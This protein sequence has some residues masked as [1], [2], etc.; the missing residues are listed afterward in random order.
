MKRD[1]EQCGECHLKDGETCDICGAHRPAKCSQLET[2]IRDIAEAHLN[3]YGADARNALLGIQARARAL[4]SAPE[5][6]I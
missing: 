5:A 4:S 1:Q 6:K 2:F 3:L